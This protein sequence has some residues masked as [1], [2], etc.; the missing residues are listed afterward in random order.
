VARRAAARAVSRAHVLKRR[1]LPTARFWV[2]SG[3]HRWTPGGF[4]SYRRVRTYRDP[5]YVHERDKHDVRRKHFEH[6]GWRR[7]AEDGIRRRDYADYDEY[8]VHQ[9]QKL[10]EILK[11]GGGFSNASVYHARVRFYRRFR[12]LVGLVPADAIIVCAGAR[13]GTEVEVLRDLGFRNAY[14]IDLNPGPDNPLVR[15]GDFHALENETASVDAIYSNSL[16]HAFDLDA[17]FAEHA[18]ALK[19]HGYALY[20]LDLTLRDPDR[21][22]PFEAVV[23]AREDAALEKMLRHFER[24]VRVETEPGWKWVLLEAKRQTPADTAP[25]AA[26]GALNQKQPQP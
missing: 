20:D 3:L 16:D 8:V 23:W 6:E 18:R 17:C 21:T 9:Q 24:V 25:Q 7:E 15:H 26:E 4:G 11:L 2:R 1:A 22:H 5:T 13:L 14:G 10:D 19:P 12:H